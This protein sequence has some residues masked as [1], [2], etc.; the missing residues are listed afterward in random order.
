SKAWLEEDFIFKPHSSVFVL[1]RNLVCDIDTIQD[2]EF[3]KI[4]YKVNHESAF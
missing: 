2:L 1:P 3:A 4:L